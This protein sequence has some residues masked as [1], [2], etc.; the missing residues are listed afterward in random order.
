MQNFLHILI[1][2]SNFDA[3]YILHSSYCLLKCTQ[4]D[5]FSWRISRDTFFW[6]V[7]VSHSH[8]KHSIQSGTFSCKL[9][10][11]VRHYFWFCTTL[12]VPRKQKKQSGSPLLAFVECVCIY[13][14]FFFF[15]V[16][17]FT[18]CLGNLNL[19]LGGSKTFWKYKCIFNVVLITRLYA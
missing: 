12:T 13:M 17:G 2:Y 3:F 6:V 14:H 7:A 9:S 5:C 10:I 8:R 1:L 16:N 4:S 11:L 18:K 15:V 19:Y